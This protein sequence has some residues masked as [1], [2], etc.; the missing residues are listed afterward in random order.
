MCALTAAYANFT[1]TRWVRQWL[2]FLSAIPLA[3]AG[4]I[5]R[6][7]TI[8]LVAQAFGADLALKIYHNLSGFIVF[9]VAILLMMGIGHVLSTTN[10]G[11]FRPW[12]G[13]P[14]S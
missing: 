6:I 9:S 10:Q 14:V 7:V 1:Q 5:T 13:A 4:N 2:L 11:G 8:A 12:R 3:I